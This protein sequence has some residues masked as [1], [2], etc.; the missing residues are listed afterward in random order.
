[1][2]R[3]LAHVSDLHVGKSDRHDRAVARLC[4][5]LV[6]AGVDHVVLTGDVTHRGKNQELARFRDGFGPLLELGRV[7]IIPGNHDRMNDDLREALMPG[8]RVQ[9]DRPEGLHLVK[10]DSTAPHNKSLLRGHGVLDEAD[11]G[12]IERQLAT[13]PEG[14]L[15]VLL[16]HHHPSPLPGDDLFD[17]LTAL[18]GLD[19]CTELRAGA[20]LLDR[21]LGRAALLL[22][23]HRHA[24]SEARHHGV[25]P[26][27][28]EQ[29][30]VFSAGGTTELG[31]FRIFK[32]RAG[33][34]VGPPVW[35]PA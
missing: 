23:G 31:R 5:A 1:M 24:A 16:V 19:W 30:E 2:T 33:K 12:E 28:A 7:S 11:L 9:V 13:V 25:K 21:A 17:R 4:A 34:L 27:G 20:R 6:A 26:T 8:P 22:H 29:L 32:H 15:P 3:S 14:A 18:V 35:V 10:V